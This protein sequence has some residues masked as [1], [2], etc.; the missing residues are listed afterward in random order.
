[1]TEQQTQQDSVAPRKSPPTKPAPKALDVPAILYSLDTRV[2]CWFAAY[3]AFSCFVVEGNSQNRGVLQLL[4]LVAI[5]AVTF[6]AVRQIPPGKEYVYMV[7]RLALIVCFSAGAWNMVNGDV[8]LYLT[9]P[10]LL[11]FL[12]TSR[13]ATALVLAIAAA[14]MPRGTD[15]LVSALLTGRF[16]LSDLPLL[17]DWNGHCTTASIV[18]ILGSGAY[19]VQAIREKIAG[20]PPSD[21][22]GGNDDDDNE[23]KSAPV[24]AVSNVVLP[25]GLPSVA[26]PQA[27]CYLAADRLKE[28]DALLLRLEG[29]SESAR[30]LIDEI[31]FRIEQLEDP[32]C[33][34]SLR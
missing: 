3:Y 19:A 8:L 11:I 12:G 2:I 5:L 7:I 17:Y 21:S 23:S 22:S 18:A 24:D 25:A 33:S 14:F 6:L 16:H 10:Q 30:P 28:I 31:S 1:M 32:N 26:E 34:S 13:G 29:C 9:A 4:I 20:S 15:E 27:G